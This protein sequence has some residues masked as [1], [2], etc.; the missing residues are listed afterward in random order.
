MIDFKNQN[1]PQV[2]RRARERE[3][4]EA[5][6]DACGFSDLH[7]KVSL[8]SYVTEIFFMHLTATPKSY[9][10][11][12]NCYFLTPISYFHEK[13][14]ASKVVSA[15]SLI[16]FE[17]CGDARG[18]GVKFRRHFGCT[19]RDASVQCAQSTVRACVESFRRRVERS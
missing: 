8:A 17:T 5:Q 4:R 18:R 19:T 7:S 2:L 15:R 16:S 3:H 9:L 14:H 6:V 12:S 11:C 1:Q 13:T 10:I